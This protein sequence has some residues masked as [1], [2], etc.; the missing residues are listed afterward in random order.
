MFYNEISVFG[1]SACGMIN[2]AGSRF[3]VIIK[4]SFLIPEAVLRV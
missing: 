3:G 2:N 4:T 1:R